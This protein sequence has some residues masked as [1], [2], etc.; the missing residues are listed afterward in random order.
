VGIFGEVTIMEERHVVTC[1]LEHE[2]K[3]PLFRRSQKVGTYR[4]KWA[5]VSGYIEEGNTPLEQAF[6]EIGEETG[7][8]EGDVELIKEGVPLEII[9]EEM[10]RK[11]VVHPFRFKVK[12]PH[13]I[14]I[15]WEHTELKWIDPEDIVE[16][17]T[18]PN[19]VE[20]WERVA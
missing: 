16:Y 2:G 18:V 10:G 5:G 14:A 15:D 11:W 13:K 4:G 1:F 7:L 17:E 12:T 3:I 6:I 8:S 20:T 9:D 19:L